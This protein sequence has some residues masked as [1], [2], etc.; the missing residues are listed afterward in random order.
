M[1]QSNQS[2]TASPTDG[3]VSSH[4][5]SLTTGLDA[6]IAQAPGE[7]DTLTAGETNQQV[8]AS[9]RKCYDYLEKLGFGRLHIQGLDNMEGPGLKRAQI[10]EPEVRGNFVL[11][12]CGDR[13]RGKTQM[14]TYLASRKAVNR[15]AMGWEHQPK[16]KVPRYYS[17]H[18]LMQ[19][20][21]GEFSDIKD[22]C[23]QSLMTLGNASGCS[24][25]VIDEFSE[26][27][28]SDYNKRTLTNLLDRRYRAM[29]PTIIITNTHSDAVADEV[30]RSIYDRCNESG[31]T[32]DCDWASYRTKPN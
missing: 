4:L 1:K 25:L 3:S 29:L 21:R 27:M 32:V 17:A 16:A 7:E 10:L 6:L 20:I 12:L 5:K 8:T 13:G 22:Q 30:G 26:L 2:T 15:R 24:L 28:G 23:Q 9:N 11:I 14:A 18:D 31:A 19:A